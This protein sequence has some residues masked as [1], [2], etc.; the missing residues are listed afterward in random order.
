MG[1]NATT[2]G[3]PCIYYGTE[4]QFDGEGSGDSA[5]RYIRESMFGGKFGAFRSHGRHFFRE[6]GQRVFQ[7]LAKIHTL[8]RESLTLR[9]GR[10]FLREISGDGATFGFPQKFGGK[11]RSIVAWSRIFNDDEML[12]AINTDADHRLTAF[13]TIDNDLHAPGSRLTCLYSTDPADIDRA[14]EVEARNGRAV[15]LS[16]PPAGFVVYR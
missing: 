1:L 14:V 4:Q 6:D 11:L 10:Q 8:R 7:E 15:A 2:L 3:I 12:C 9:R 16:V 13:V 5:D